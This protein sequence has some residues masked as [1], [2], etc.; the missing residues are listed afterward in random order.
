MDAF[1]NTFILLFIVIFVSCNNSIFVESE[2]QLVSSGFEFPE[3]PAWDSDN[4]LY[5]SN[6]YGDWIAKIINDKADTLILK[7]DSTFQNTNGLYVTNDFIYACDFGLGKILKISPKGNVTTL[8]S[9]YEGKKFNRPN[10]LIVMNNNDIYFTDPKSYGRDKPDGRLFFYDSDQNKV[11]LAADN[12]AFPNGL[13]L[14]PFDKNFYVCES[15]KNQIVR[16]EIS[17]NGLLKNKQK[18][19]E[20]PGGDPDGIDFDM[21]GN[22][23][24]A[25]F[26]TGIVFVISPDAEIIE[27]IKTPGLKP[28]NLEFGDS[29]LKTLYLTEDETNSVYKIRVRIPG[30]KLHNNIQIKR[31]QTI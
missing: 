9:E 5:V 24:V 11:Y 20:L 1:K 26:G 18:F 3:G 19:I 8:I 17:E 30:Y 10:D 23:Y 22:L 14:S 29:D 13:A 7:S 27:K 12:L 6:C 28:S 16:F 21:E 25:H 4:T 15:A 2:W 31:K